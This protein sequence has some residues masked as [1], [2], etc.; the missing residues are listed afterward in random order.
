MGA[1]GDVGSDLAG[2]RSRSH[3]PGLTSEVVALGRIGGVTEFFLHDGELRERLGCGGELAV[4]G[5]DVGGALEGM[6]GAFVI[7]RRPAFVEFAEA[8]CGGEVAWELRAEIRRGRLVEEGQEEFVLGDGPG[9]LAGGELSL[10]EE[11]V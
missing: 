9:G 6:G 8:E 7:G 1:V 4:G 3:L 2:E 11:E 5:A 10:G